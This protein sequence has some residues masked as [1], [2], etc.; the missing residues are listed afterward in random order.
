MNR[1][2]L[3]FA[4]GVLVITGCATATSPAIIEMPTEIIQLSNTP[5]LAL[6]PKPTQIT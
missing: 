4:V 1:I 5:T 2:I 3:L 6:S